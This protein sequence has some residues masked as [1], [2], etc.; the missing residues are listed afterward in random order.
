MLSKIRKYFERQKEARLLVTPC[1][2]ALWKMKS[3]VRDSVPFTVFGKN[4]M[5]DGVERFSEVTSKTSE[6]KLAKNTELMPFF[7]TKA[8]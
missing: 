3:L 8:S 1:H 2:A 5:A 6:L 4:I 7:I